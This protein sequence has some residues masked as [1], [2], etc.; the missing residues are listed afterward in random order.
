MSDLEIKPIHKI[1][2]LTLSTI[3]YA[4]NENSDII[5]LHVYIFHHIKSQLHLG[6]IGYCEKMATFEA[7]EE[8]K[9]RVNNILKLLDIC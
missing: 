8:R 9:F 2:R 7:S 6:H 4:K 3:R 5:A 1:F